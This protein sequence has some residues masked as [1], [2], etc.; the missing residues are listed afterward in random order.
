MHS[1][2]AHNQHPC[3]KACPR[4]KCLR[5]I[6]PG[7]ERP[8]PCRCV[9]TSEEKWRELFLLQYTYADVPDVFGQ[10]NT[11][12]TALGEASN[13]HFN[14]N[15][16]DTDALFDTGTEQYSVGNP[17][18]PTTQATP[19]S[20]LDHFASDTFSSPNRVDAALVKALCERVQILEQRTSQPGQREWDLEMVVANVWQ[21]LVR[22]NSP[23][24]QRNS[25][26]WQ[27]VARHAPKV[28]S[29]I[30]SHN[31]VQ[32]QDMNVREWP[33][34][35]TSSFPDVDWAHLRNTAGLPSSLRNI[36]SDSG[37]LT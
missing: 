25:A 16:I 15:T 17:T 18:M 37:Y 2:A 6:P 3:S 11:S 29:P 7:A 28:L 4:R 24:A 13:E 5:Y 22:S 33:P 19:L 35:S 1:C 20:A 8:F 30:Q 31:T 14:F 26:V 9:T 27:V 23:E 32:P 34:S 12:G 10:N 36:R 21:A